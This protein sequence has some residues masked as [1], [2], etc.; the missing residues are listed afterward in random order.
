MHNL[1]VHWKII[2]RF[3]SN[4]NLNIVWGWHRDT[5]I[6]TTLN[7]TQPNWGDQTSFPIDFRHG[8][9]V[10]SNEMRFSIETK[11]SYWNTSRK[12]CVRWQT[13]V[14]F[15]ARI[16]RFIH[17]DKWNLH[18]PRCKKWA[19]N[20]ILFFFFT[21]IERQYLIFLFSSEI[22]PREYQS[23]IKLSRASRALLVNRLYQLAWP[24]LRV[25]S[26]RLAQG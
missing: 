17:S 22:S 1:C 21:Q 16:F 10:T 5:R 7:E 24:V 14:I 4:H 25:S 23:Q 3:Y 11:Q 12:L 2:I 18:I 19:S 9:F 26:H 13:K 15:S 20:L 6:E 8:N